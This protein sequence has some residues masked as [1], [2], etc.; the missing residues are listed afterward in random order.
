ME[1][2]VVLRIRSLRVRLKRCWSILDGSS[3]IKV[4]IS[5]ITF[6]KHLEYCSPD[7]R[8]MTSLT[9]CICCTLSVTCAIVSRSTVRLHPQNDEST[10]QLHHNPNGVRLNEVFEPFAGQRAFE[11]DFKLDNVDEQHSRQGNSTIQQIG[12]PQWSKE[13][14]HAWNQKR[15]DG[16]DITTTKA[17][18]LSKI[19]NTATSIA[20]RDTSFA[21]LL[22]NI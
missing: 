15:S 1:A 14:I 18:K 13:S 10:V 6:W 3:R 4:S 2:I 21:D 9:W 22:T 20:R 5:S 12:G 8:F 16:R 11:L 19:A 7:Y 17:I